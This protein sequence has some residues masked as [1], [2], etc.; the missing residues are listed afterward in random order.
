MSVTITFSRGNFLFTECILYTLLNN[1][2]FECNFK[3]ANVYMF[4]KLIWQT[5]YITFSILYPVAE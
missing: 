1:I 3:I 4:L 5:V 2:I